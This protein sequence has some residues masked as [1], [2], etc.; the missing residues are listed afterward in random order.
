MLRDKG[1]AEFAEAIAQLRAAGVVVQGLLAG[2]IDPDN[3]A[4]FAE[5]EL[6]A[7]EAKCGVRWLGHCD[8]M[9][10][11]FS[12]AHIVCLPSYREGLPKALIEAAA[13]GRALV[14]TDVPGCRQVV[15]DGVNGLLVPAR[16]VGPLV[17]AIGRLVADPQLRAAMATAARR[18]A[19]QEFGIQQVIAR[20]LDVYEQIHR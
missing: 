7:L 16:E 6:R 14:T 4:S 10:R 2:A 18:R 11:L 3:P 15:A 1:V 8:D 20:T 13:A 19:E 5:P 9:P 17:A 12:S